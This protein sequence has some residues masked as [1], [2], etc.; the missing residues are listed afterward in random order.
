MA[1][2]PL[3][4]IGAFGTHLVCCSG[5][6]SFTGTVPSSIKVGGYSSE[7]DGIAAFV[8]WF[9]A[10]DVDFQRCHVADLRNDVFALMLAA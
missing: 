6:Y 1:N 10:Q 2:A 4:S 7:Q 9:K 5:I 8:S 3:L